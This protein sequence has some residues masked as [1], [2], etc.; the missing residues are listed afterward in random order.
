M[1]DQV[2]FDA[3]KLTDRALQSFDQFMIEAGLKVEH[4][5]PLGD[6]L[7]SV[8]LKELGRRGKVSVAGGGSYDDVGNSLITRH[9]MI[10]SS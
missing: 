4:L 1:N 2:N 6:A 5:S 7:W 3:S 9:Y 8:V 10:K